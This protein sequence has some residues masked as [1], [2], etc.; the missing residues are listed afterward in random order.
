MAR[1]ALIDDDYAME[2][3]VENLCF[4]GHVANR[5]N[6]A[7]EALQSIEEI[8]KNDLVILDIIMARTADAS[9][10]SISG[11]KT[12]GM[13]ILRAIRDKN[14]TLPVI[15]Y[16]AITDP[17]LIDAI[18]SIANTTFISKWGTPS[19]RDFV[20]TVEKATNAPPT[21]PL[22]NS[23]IIHGHD[24]AEKLSLKNF[25]QNTLGLPEP[26]I[27]HEQPNLGRT[28][29]EKLEDYALRS[30]LAFVLLTPDD[31]ISRGAGTSDDKRRARQ[32]VIFE[33]GYFLGVFGRSSGRTFLLHKGK[34]DLPSDLAG[35]IYI[36]ISNG[37]AAAGE[38][39][40]KELAHVIG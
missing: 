18:R 31:K 34:L 12:T 20:A 37:I 17:D 11:D 10:P 16:S 39:I 9:A 38:E 22:P 14:S 26:I 33:L 27:L 29:I 15:V 3:L 35:V 36:D 28:I 2:V 23:F 40:R 5:I 6:S 30:D 13:E 24:T 1:I 4:R 8:A 19:L 21:M 25:L 32:N 7:A